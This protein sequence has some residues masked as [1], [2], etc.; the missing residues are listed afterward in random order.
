M[1]IFVKAK[2]FKAS[3]LNKI[4]SRMKVA[5]YE[6][7]WSIRG[8]VKIYAFYKKSVFNKKWKRWEKTDEIK[9]EEIQAISYFCTGKRDLMQAARETFCDTRNSVSP[10]KWAMRK[11]ESN[12]WPFESEKNNQKPEKNRKG[13]N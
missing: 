12:Y 11:S 5:K 8:P 3:A 10:R 6:C 4:F 7:T 9:T 2:R 13:I 1:K